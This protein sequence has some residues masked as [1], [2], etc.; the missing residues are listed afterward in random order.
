M[1]LKCHVTV[2]ISLIGIASL[3]GKGFAQ[4]VIPSEFDPLLANQ[5][6]IDAGAIGDQVP[7]FSDPIGTYFEFL[8]TS[9]IQSNYVLRYPIAANSRFEST[10]FGTVTT[11]AFSGNLWLYVPGEFQVD[12]I[13]Q[14]APFFVYLRNIDPPVDSIDFLFKSQTVDVSITHESFFKNGIGQY[15]YQDII[16]G[17][18]CDTSRCDANLNNVEASAMPVIV[19]AGCG[20]A[21]GDL[22]VPGFQYIDNGTG[23]LQIERVQQ[24]DFEREDFRLVFQHYSFYDKDDFLASQIFEI[25]LFR[26]GDTNQDGDVSLLDVFNLVSCISN[27]KYQYQCDLN[28]DGQVDLLDIQPFVDLLTS[29]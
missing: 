11:E 20:G 9:T 24:F 28:Q 29:R 27:G 15:C 5:I 1:S 26:T 18:P 22:R 8:D 17:K 25:P 2:L 19:L 10:Q 16:K 4:T 3:E 13:E 6:Q 12:S 23:T 21:G 7:G 14:S